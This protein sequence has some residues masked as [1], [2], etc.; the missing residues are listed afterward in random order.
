MPRPSDGGRTPGNPGPARPRADGAPL[1]VIAARAQVH[2]QPAG[3]V[4]DL[5]QR[6]H[7]YLVTAVLTTPQYAEAARLGQ[8]VLLAVQQ[9]AGGAD[10]GVADQRAGPDG[11]LGGQKVVRGF[12]RYRGRARSHRDCRRRLRSRPGYWTRRLCNTFYN[13]HRAARRPVR[14]AAGDHVVNRSIYN[15][16][17]TSPGGISPDRRLLL[18][19]GPS[20]ALR[21]TD[22]RSPDDAPDAMLAEGMRIVIRRDGRASR[23]RRPVRAY[24]CPRRTKVAP[25]GDDAAAGHQ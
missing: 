22:A 11:R 2:R 15:T 8:G 19:P 23:L 10:P 17:S 3:V 12:G 6:N 24:H 16:R 21:G 5:G 9:L 7:V 13:G 4:P 1:G 20:A 25:G 18:R 14:A